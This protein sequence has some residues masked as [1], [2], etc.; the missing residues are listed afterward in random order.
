[1]PPEIVADLREGAA[2][3]FARPPAEKVQY[4][5]GPYGNPLG[6]Y[7]GAGVEAVA[8]SR[9][10]HGSD[11]GGADETA[12]P[13]VVESFVFKPDEATKPKPQELDVPGRAYFSLR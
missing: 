5:H 9:D 7:T 6:G 3:F 1:M 2:R 10:G 11:A 12:P 13:D 4:D 8:R